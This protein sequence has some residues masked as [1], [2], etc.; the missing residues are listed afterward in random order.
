[1]ATAHSY[2][3]G[4]FPERDSEEGDPE[5]KRWMMN[6][7]ERA[8]LKFCIE[9]MNQTYH[10][11]EYKSVLIY[12]MTLLNH[13][14]CGWWDP[15][16]YPLILSRV[17]KITRF[18]FI[19]KTFAAAVEDIETNSA[20]DSGGDDEL[21]S[22]PPTSPMRHGDPP[23]HIQWSPH[24]SRKTFQNLIYSTG[25]IF[26]FCNHIARGVRPHS[27]LMYR[28]QE[29]SQVFSLSARLI[30][31]DPGMVLRPL[32]ASWQ[33]NVAQCAHALG[34][35]PEWKGVNAAG[36]Y[37]RLLRDDA[38][39]DGVGQRVARMLLVLNYTDICRRPDEYWPPRMKG[40]PV[41]HV[42]DCITGAYLNDTSRNPTK[43]DH[44][45]IHNHLRQGRWLWTLARQVGVG[46]V[47]TCSVEKNVTIRNVVIDAVAAHTVS[48][49][50]GLVR[51]LCSMEPVVTVL[52]FGRL[53]GELFKAVKAD[54]SGILGLSNLRRIHED[55]QAFLPKPHGPEGE[56][57]TIYV[58]PT[59]QPRRKN[60][61]VPNVWGS[62][63]KSA[64]WLNAIIDDHSAN[65]VLLGLNLDEIGLPPDKRKKRIIL[66]LLHT[67]DLSRD[68]KYITSDQCCCKQSEDTL[69]FHCLRDGYQY[70]RPKR[71][72]TFA[73]IDVILNIREPIENIEILPLWKDLKKLVESDGKKLQSQYSFFAKEK[74]KI[75]ES[76]EIVGIGGFQFTTNL[77][78]QID[79]QNRTKRPLMVYI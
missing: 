69:F 23:A 31:P 61:G 53:H 32:L 21:S 43:Q 45:A 8:Y 48:T 33:E 15:E 46:I 4:D 28:K 36:A 34:L 51:L 42:I 74:I 47:L 38:I 40:K 72:I 57:D 59:V 22:S 60:I 10:T 25:H 66:A 65:P 79:P 37:A 12:A 67:A 29:R 24:P 16:S 76:P 58:K 18:M 77:Q 75:V 63:F 78:T 20:Y 62:I 30:V 26:L 70:N 50:P 35:P 17:I 1:M 9:L 6:D 5:Q 39:R 56:S 54:G 27:N 14:E 49:R 52:M 13:I 2:A 68:V 19:Q 64:E 55:N 73:D 3:E 44:D 41:A 7:M 71:K 11:Q